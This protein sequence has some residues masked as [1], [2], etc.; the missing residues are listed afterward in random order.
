[1]QEQSQNSKNKK[2][3]V[4]LGITEYLAS[5]LITL[6]SIIF[7]YRARNFTLDDAMIYYR[8][9]RNAINGIGLVYN[10]GEYINALS[11]PL[12]TYLGLAIS[13]IFGNIPLTMHIFSGIFLLLTAFLLIKLMRLNN[14]E[15]PYNFLPSFML[16]SSC[17]FYLNFGLEITL[18]LFLVCLCLYYFFYKKDY[19]LLLCASLLILTRGEYLFFVIILAIYYFIE[20]WRFP[21]FKYFILP[22]IIVLCFYLINYLIYG[23]FLPETLSAK[24]AQGI[25]GIF[26]KYPFLRVGTM[27]Y[28][29]NW[30][31]FPIYP[32]IFLIIMAIISFIGIVANIK[33]VRLIQI[34]LLYLIALTI[35]YTSLNIPN[36]PWYYSPYFLFGFI[37]FS[38]G[39]KAIKKYLSSK[40]TEN[41]SI[42]FINALASIF[43]IAV[44]IRSFIILQGE[45]KELDYKN[46]GLW[47]KENLPKDTKIACIEIGHIGWYSEL[48][49]VDILGLISPKSAEYLR[50]GDLSSWYE[51]YKPDFIVV[52]NPIWLYESGVEKYLEKGELIKD[53][54]FQYPGFLLLKPAMKKES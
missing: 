25:S 33:S 10:P 31:I 32:K 13:Y 26:G 6:I 18:S 7:I 12:Y 35:F 46:I 43:I 34:T 48:Y 50:N 11:S 14:I 51:Y 3:S 8:Y 39:L 47:L 29:S 4:N 20:N 23:T 21:K 16:V 45:T 54:K 52:H 22:I 5:T 37:Y 42:Q 15:F 40:L 53:E 27:L 17:F 49:I 30:M 9:F 24:I 2:S 28:N 19:Q 41:I 38:Y 44:L 36:Y 1:M